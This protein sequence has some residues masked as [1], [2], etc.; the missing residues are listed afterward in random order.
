M[1][2]IFK[3]KIFHLFIEKEEQNI[4][5]DSYQ[6]DK[7]WIN[8]KNY[9]IKFIDEYETMQYFTKGWNKNKER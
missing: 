2:N 3:N 4:P 1:N 7:R 5:L 6:V 9:G 8:V